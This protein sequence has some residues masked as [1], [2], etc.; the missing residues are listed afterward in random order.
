M[1]IYNRRTGA[2]LNLFIENIPLKTVSKY[3]YN[4][5]GHDN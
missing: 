5:L 3:D 4:V 1:S 2:E